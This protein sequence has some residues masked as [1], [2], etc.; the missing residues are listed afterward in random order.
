MDQ[1]RD[2]LSCMGY[3]NAIAFDGSTS[4]TL[5]K[6]GKILVSPDTRKNSTIPAGLNISVP[7]K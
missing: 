5:A 1:I 7:S 3:D 6:D 2:K 4:S